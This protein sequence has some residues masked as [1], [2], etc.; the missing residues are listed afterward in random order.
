M[1]FCQICGQEVSR[2]LG[3]PAHARK[4]KNDFERIVGRQPE[5]YDEV[6]AFYEGDLDEHE[7]EHPQLGEFDGSEH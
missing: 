3:A 4:H 1:P 7:H 6:I 5:D 2:G